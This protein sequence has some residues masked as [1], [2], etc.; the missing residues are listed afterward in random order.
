IIIVPPGASAGGVLDVWQRPVTDVGQTGPDKGQGGKYLILP[1]DGPDVINPEF[2]VRRSPTNQV[3]FA[4]RGL[5][6]DQRAAEALPC[7]YQLYA[8]DDRPRPPTTKFVPVGGK[9]WKST[10][11]NDLRYWQYLH[12]VLAPE[13][14]EAR[15]YFFYGM[16]LPLGID[17]N[18]PFNPDERQKKI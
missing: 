17:Q 1:P 15:D 14:P 16:L 5:G 3:W 18:K 11:P 4:T 10:Q 9:D 12:D 7:K 8:Y 13:R 2:I 6:S